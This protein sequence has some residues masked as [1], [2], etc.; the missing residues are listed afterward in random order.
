[1][2]A[3]TAIAL[4]AVAAVAR[5]QQASSLLPR[6]IMETMTLGQAQKMCGADQAVTC[7]T[8]DV[9]GSN[10]NPEKADGFLANLFGNV[11][12]GDA[13][14]L[15]GQCSAI[16]VPGMLRT[17]LAREPILIHLSSHWRNRHPQEEVQRRCRMLRQV[18]VSRCEYS[19]SPGGR[20][21]S[22]LTCISPADLSTSA[23]PAS[24]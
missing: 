15:L 21:R 2:Y 24:P 4:F 12:G 10:M 14:S 18:P 13:S 5:P 6:E 20:N 16:D 11:L 22:P 19:Q 1:M 8:Q 9:D 23:Y 7:C 17:T 3:S